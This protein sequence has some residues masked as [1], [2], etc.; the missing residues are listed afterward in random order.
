LIY[1]YYVEIKSIGFVIALGIL[2][3]INFVTYF[4]VAQTDPGFI[5][6]NI[7][8]AETELTQVNYTEEA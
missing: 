5:N 6:Q 8:K 1:F 4:R 2:S 7:F 3:A